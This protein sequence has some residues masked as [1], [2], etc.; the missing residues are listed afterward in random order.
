[1]SF[2]FEKLIVYQ[3]A[4]DFADRV[5]TATETFP[6]VMASSSI[7]SIAHLSR[8]R[9]ISPKGM[10]GSQRPIIETSSG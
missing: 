10:V 1:V 5:F 3:K 8:S 7:N 6:V 2:D 4:V 9:P